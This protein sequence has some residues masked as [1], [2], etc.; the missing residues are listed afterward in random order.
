MNPAEQ[1]ESR[2]SLDSQVFTLTV[3]GHLTRTE[4][5]A[6]TNAQR[7]EWIKRLIEREKRRKDQE[8][9]ARRST[10]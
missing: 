8:D 4:V 2:E 3:D 7:S 6:M 10:K 1:W 5:M 9:K